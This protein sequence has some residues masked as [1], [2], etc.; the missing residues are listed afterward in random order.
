[1]TQPIEF[2]NSHAGAAAAA[3]T[4][5]SHTNCQSAVRKNFPPAR[6]FSHAA[7]VWQ[8]RNGA[9]AAVLSVILQLTEFEL[10]INGK[11]PLFK[12]TTFRIDT[13]DPSLPFVIFYF[14]V[15]L[16]SRSA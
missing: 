11:I 16:V 6:T 10:A 8:L 5:G 9:I 3:S 1:L 15:N 14:S 2:H 4:G 7:L 12:L 13:G